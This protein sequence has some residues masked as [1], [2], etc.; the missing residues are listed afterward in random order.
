MN[1]GGRDG[2]TGILF[3]LQEK[4]DAREEIQLV[5]VPAS[6]WGLLSAGVLDA[7]AKVPDLLRRG[8]RAGEGR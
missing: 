5:G 6:V 7:E 8:I 3:A 4:R 1:S 2:W